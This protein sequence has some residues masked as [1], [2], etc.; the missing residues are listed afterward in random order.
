MVAAT[1]M[2]LRS[3]A[4][5]LRELPGHASLQHSMRQKGRPGLETQS[6]LAASKEALKYVY[7][8]EFVFTVHEYCML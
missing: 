3:I 7:S 1:A 5:S 8:T 6:G 2:Q 4:T